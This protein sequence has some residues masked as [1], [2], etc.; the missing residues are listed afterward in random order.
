MWAAVDSIRSRSPI[1][2]V[3]VGGSTKSRKSREPPPT[4]SGLFTPPP[5]LY[6]VPE[7]KQLRDGATKPVPA[8]HET[9]RAPDHAP[10]L[11]VRPEELDKGLE[12]AP[13]RK[14]G[15][16][17]VDLACSPES[18]VVFFGWVFFLI[19][20]GSPHVLRAHMGVHRTCGEPTEIELTAM[21]VGLN[22][23]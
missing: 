19:P 12:R 21:G 16:A 11:R 20:L 9:L 17:H 3:R 1:R 2:I 8:K 4:P 10:F 23:S 15:H 13:L 18:A 5:L 14:R 22:G 6:Y 7:G